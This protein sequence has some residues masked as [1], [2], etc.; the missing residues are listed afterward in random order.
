MQLYNTLSRTLEEFEPLNPPH[1]G[2]YAC[3]PTVY[4]YAHIGHM[5]KYINDDVLR[6]VLELNGYEVKHVMNITDVG[7]LA[8]DGDEGEDKLEKGAKKFGKSVLDVAHFFEKD[9]WDALDA[10]NVKRPTIV[11]RATEHIQDQIELIEIL[12]E[13]GYA[14]KT[15]QAVYFDIS[16]FAD[17][18]KLSGQQLED[19]LEGAR[20]DVVVDPKKRNPQDFALWFFTIGRFENHALKWESPWGTGFPGWHIECSA[21]AMKYLGLSLDIHTGG[22]DHIAV[23]HTNERAQSEAASGVQFVKYWVHN[24][25]LMVDDAKMSKSKEN[26]YTLSDFHKKSISPLA[27]RYLSFQVHYRTEMN[28]TWKSLQAAQHALE[29]LYDVAQDLPQIGGAGCI[30]YDRDFQEAVSTD[31]NMPKALGLLWEMLRSKNTDKDKAASLYMMDQIFGFKIAE[32]VSAMR[33][34]PSEITTVVHEREQM[35]KQKRYT[36]ADKMRKEIEAKGYMIKD[37]EDGTTQILKKV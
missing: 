25:M 8:S 21:M 31:L 12:Q 36:D 9:F 24:E 4:D 15:A 3:G 1:V 20:D 17:Y 22:V 35:R 33:S 7:H 2:M 18:T 34:I 30:E 27:F 23:H 37:R 11:A 10:V 32:Q 28:F 16:K 29:R 13:K 14:Y 19:K 5:R 26:F 6:R